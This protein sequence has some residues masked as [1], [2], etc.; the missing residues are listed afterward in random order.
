MDTLRHIGHRQPGSMPVPSLPECRW[1]DMSR[2]SSHAVH[3]LWSV[4]LQFRPSSRA[5]PRLLYPEQLRGLVV[6][7]H[8][9]HSPH[10]PSGD[11]GQSQSC[12]MMYLEVLSGWRRAFSV[13]DGR[14]REPTT[15]VGIGIGAYLSLFSLLGWLF[16]LTCLVWSDLWL[17]ERTADTKGKVLLCCGDELVKWQWMLAPWIFLIML[18]QEEAMEIAIIKWSK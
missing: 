13:Q 15:S 16:F 12:T 5:S 8:P 9:H 2:T 6:S 1:W 14:G 18:E 7:Q 4:F 3:H 10:R 11:L 17:H